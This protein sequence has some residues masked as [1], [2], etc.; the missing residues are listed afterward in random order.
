MAS[1]GIRIQFLSDADSINA[2]SR[3]AAMRSVATEPVTV[4]MSDQRFGIVEIAAII[5]IVKESAEVV[6]LLAD[7]YKKLQGCRKI[8]VKTPK[9]SV[10]IEGDG[11]L[12]TDAIQE[13]VEQADIF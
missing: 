12:S 6:G 3:V 13:R 5:A 11:S 10:T 8:T 9:G 7:A 4:P 2:L 1:A